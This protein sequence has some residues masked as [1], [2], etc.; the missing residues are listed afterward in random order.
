MQNITDIKLKGK[1][2]LIRVDYNV[3][4]REGIVVDDFRIRSSL[5]TIKYCLNEGASIVLMSHLGRPK[6]KIN[7]KM[8]LNPV[9]LCLETLLDREVLFSDDCISKK[10]IELSNQIAT[11]E[12]HLLENLRFYSEEIYNEAK[13]SACLA[14]HGSIYINDA[15]ATSHRSHASNVGVTN[16]MEKT[17][18]G[19]LMEK[20]YKYLSEKTSNPPTPCALLLGGAKID[21]KLDLIHNMMRKIDTILIGGAMAFTFLKSKGLD[22]GASLVQNDSLSMAEKILS[23]AENNNIDV[24]L[25]VDF[26]VASKMSEDAPCRIA[27]LEELQNDEAGY[28]IGPKTT[29]N[30]EMLLADMKMIL[31]NGPMGVCEIPAFST[32]TEVIA[33]VVRDKTQEGAISIIGGGDTASALK[34]MSITDGFTHISTGGGASLQLMSGKKL[35]AIE[36]L[37]EYV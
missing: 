36:A 17:A 16:F 33:S 34:N 23:I 22:V 29:M 28:D 6:G 30:F 26:V 4:L 31:W 21:D 32:G 24:A 25:P 13:F 15:F 37:H 3:P 18:L 35:P 11:G 14:K 10:A 19:L 1:R 12:I 5:P 8:S 2:V 27:N 20:E 9:V 7:L